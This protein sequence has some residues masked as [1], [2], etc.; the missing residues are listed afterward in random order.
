MFYLVRMDWDF[1]IDRHRVPLIGHVAELFVKIGLTEGATIERVPKPVYR[2]VLRILRAAESAVRRLIIAAARN[3]VVEPREPRPSRPRQ[4]PSNRPKADGDAKPKR[5]RGIFFKLFDPLKRY[6]RRFKKIRRAEPRARFIDY[7]PREAFLRRFYGPPPAVP[8]PA[9]QNA[10][11][12]DDGTVNAGPL[13]RRLLAIKDALEDIPRQAMRLARWQAQAL[14]D[15][16]PQRH[17][18][19]RAG[20]PPGWRSRPTHEVHEILKECHWL[21]RQLPALDTS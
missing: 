7:D 12:T 10:D 13:V 9:P 4:K 19:L 8:A 21:V 17:S 14:E 6:G 5:K 2:S 16:R 3:I 18:P 20:Q 11:P 1:A 15:R